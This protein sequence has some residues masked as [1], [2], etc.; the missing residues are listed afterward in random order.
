MFNCE[1]KDRLKD[2]LKK[3]EETGV[4]IKVTEPTDW[5]SSLVVVE[6]PKGK[7]RVCL[8]PRDLNAANIQNMRCWASAQPHEHV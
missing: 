7:L 3:M 1:L 2:E 8:D 5:V 6:K 4:I